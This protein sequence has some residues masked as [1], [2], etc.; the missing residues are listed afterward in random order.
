MK[1]AA[2]LLL[3][4]LLVARP[5]QT[6]G[7]EAWHDSAVPQSAFTAI[8][9]PRGAALL[10][11]R[12]V[13]PTAVANAADLTGTAVPPPGSDARQALPAAY[14]SNATGRLAP[15]PSLAPASRPSLGVAASVT[16]ELSGVASWYR[17]VAGQA[18]A[19]PRLR[20]AL[21]PGWRGSV[22][23]VCAA[24]CVR[25]TLSDF[26]VA[27]RLIDLDYRSFGALAPLSQGLVEVTIS[28]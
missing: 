18:A 8:T 24:S 22:V 23:T 25:V 10:G 5:A 4:L 15:L 1:R 13:A 21:G 28:W 9:P 12:L 2:A 26:M 11:G 20:S 7:V 6:V 14:T 3:L 17:Y 19:G 16:G 27:D